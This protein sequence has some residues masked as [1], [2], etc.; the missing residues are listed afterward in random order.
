[1]NFGSCRLPTADTARSECADRRKH[2]QAS[3]GV[4]V[5]PLSLLLLRFGVNFG[6][7]VAFYS[8]WISSGSFPFVL[9]HSHHIY[10]R[11]LRIHIQTKIHPACFVHCVRDYYYLFAH[12]FMAKFLPKQIILIQMERRKL[13]LHL[14]MRA[15]AR[16]VGS[17][18]LM[19]R[20]QYANNKHTV[21]WKRKNYL[22]SGESCLCTEYNNKYARSRRQIF[23]HHHHN[24][25]FECVWSLK[26]AHTTKCNDISLLLPCLRSA[27][28]TVWTTWSHVKLFKYENSS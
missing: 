21:K 4:V 1:M 19:R 17:A 9:N 14:G 24:I 20:A 6:F 23:I 3:S 28:S 22:C 5:F 11:V 7:L 13:H 2:H 26:Q 16:V 15:H 18:M 8:F 12:C 27:P 10:L 25:I